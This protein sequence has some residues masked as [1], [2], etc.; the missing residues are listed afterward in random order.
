MASPCAFTRLTPIAERTTDVTVEFRVPNVDGK[1]AESLGATF[2]RLYTQ[3]WDQDEAMMTQRQKQLD[4][5]FRD[6]GV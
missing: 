3:L 5:G 1:R 2:V 6:A 4:R